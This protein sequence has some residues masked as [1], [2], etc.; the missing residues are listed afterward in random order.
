MS[1][2]LHDVLDLPETEQKST[3]DWSDKLKSFR[4]QFTD[5]LKT[6]N[7]GL[8]SA[9]SHAAE[10]LHKEA[11]EKRE[12][13][14]AAYHKTCQQIESNSDSAEVTVDRVMSATCALGEQAS[15][16]ASDAVE[17]HRRWTEREGDFGELAVKVKELSDAKH[18]KAATLEKLVDG[19]RNH[20]V[21][22]N[23]KAAYDAFEKVADK[24][25]SIY[26]D[27]T[28]NQVEP[29]SNKATAQ[30]SQR[31]V[32]G[33]GGY[34]Y[35]QH[36]DGRIFIV[37]SPRS[38]NK[39]IELRQG[40]K[41]FKAVFAEIGPFPHPDQAAEHTNS[42][43]EASSL[44]DSLWDAGS[45]VVNDIG[46]MVEDAAEFIQETAADVADGVADLLGFG[47]DEEQI[48]DE[49]NSQPSEEQEQNEDSPE[50]LGGAETATE[51]KL[52]EF[53]EAMK[54]I[55][56]EVDGKPVSVRPPYHWNKENKVWEMETDPKTG[57]KK[58][59][60]VID[61]ETGKKKHVPVIDP[62]TG[63]QKTTPHRIKREALEARKNNPK[64]NNL[65]KKIFRGENKEFGKGATTGK[66]T[67]EQMKKFIEESL[68]Q[69]L[70]KDTSAQGMKNYLDEFGISTDCSG[71]VS[72]G[73]NFLNDGDMIRGAN[74][75]VDASNTGTGT[76]TKD[77]SK[78]AKV[79]KPSDLAAGDVMAKTGHVRLVTDVDIEDDGVYFTTV[80]ST[81]A[82]ITDLGPDVDI[83]SGVGEVR[84]RFKNPNKFE[85]IEHKK[86]GEFKRSKSND[87]YVYTRLKGLKLAVPSGGSSGGDSSS[88]EK[89]S[90]SDSATSEGQTT[91]SP[92]SD[93]AAANGASADAKGG[94]AASAL[95][96][97]KKGIDWL[98]GVEKLRLKPYDDQTGK[99]IT[100]W[101]EGATIG[102][103]HL[104]S[105]GDWSK[106]QSG[107]N[108]QQAE[109]LFKKDLAPF[110]K[111][112]QSGVTSKI[113]QQQFDAMVILAFNI[114][115]SGFKSSS[116]LK[117]VNDPD[118]KT[119]Y[120]DL[121]TAWKAWNKSQGKVL[122]GLQNRRK[123][124]WNIYSKGVYAH[125]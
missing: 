82:D 81:T 93:D 123:A 4:E 114:G 55:V 48:A 73:L 89:P 50:L 19:I 34:E 59:K 112:V 2:S 68:K 46:E 118:A 111:A 58:K 90:G 13:V 71:L 11:A 27:F 42:S 43:N 1:N 104:I 35:E 12:K 51:K 91:Q 33:G 45:D 18:D 75:L 125:W 30:S 23:F 117:L 67:P 97:S 47:G 70:I 5:A 94:K 103:G 53:T 9:A 44:L 57:K 79:K 98:K 63:K 61:P 41:G 62:K 84:W 107:I 120:K 101:V 31:T 100:A 32:P 17:M 109:A 87:V 121:E 28:K 37:K 10:V 60:E 102:Y 8:Q 49:T 92:S 110:V 40:G 14:I 105:S 122:K 119:S 65:I 7:E 25:A 106:Y 85:K 38:G 108:E 88:S 74:E 29:E 39:R 64:V 15:S 56:V 72:Q 86:S 6:V 124:E 76:M 52:A 20:T 77:R 78:F 66:A 22:R 21:A 115:E 83:G 113:T 96:L 69:N 16:L 3:D 26:D 36:A 80:E 99:D 24:V 54:N 95:S 116:V